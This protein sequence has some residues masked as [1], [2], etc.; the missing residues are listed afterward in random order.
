MTDSRGHRY[1]D[2]QMRSNTEL[3]RSDF[4]RADEMRANG[5]T[6][7]QIRARLDVKTDSRVFYR[8][9]RREGIEHPPEKRR[10]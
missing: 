3:T 4:M 5:A 1:I 9:W 7:D 8:Y 10:S 2:R 6:W